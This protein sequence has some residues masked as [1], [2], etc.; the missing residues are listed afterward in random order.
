[1]KV[2]LE[3]ELQ[4]FS[5]SVKGLFEDFNKRVGNQL[6]FI[7]GADRSSRLRSLRMISASRRQG[8]F[9]RSS[10]RSLSASGS[11]KL[12]SDLI[13]SYS[14]WMYVDWRGY[15]RGRLRNGLGGVLQ[16]NREGW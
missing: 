1:M 12:T 4:A 16:G 10:R 13:S 7:K 3:N 9:W 6:C 14:K 11:R 2:K 15:V 5:T 8:A